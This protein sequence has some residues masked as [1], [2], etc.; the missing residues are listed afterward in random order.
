[1]TLVAIRPSV[2]YY[3][4]R[5]DETSS[6]SSTLTLSIKFL[7]S[8]SLSTTAEVQP[9]YTAVLHVMYVVLRQVSRMVVIPL[10]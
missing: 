7:F 3:N 6:S 4:S 1:M 9:T 10:K 8:V 5:S 2:K